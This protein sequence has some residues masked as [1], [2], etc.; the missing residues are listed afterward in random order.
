MRK[1]ITAAQEA[2]VQHL[3][4][5]GLTDPEPILQKQLDPVTE[6]MKEERAEP[7]NISGLPLDDSGRP[8]RF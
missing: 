3:D 8:I 1:K 4:E 2:H 6:R 5:P 7:K